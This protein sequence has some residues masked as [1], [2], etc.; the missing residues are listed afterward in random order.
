MSDE[1]VRYTMRTAAV[2]DGIYMRANCLV[3]ADC[4]SSTPT[5]VRTAE[6]ASRPVEG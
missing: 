5:A 1:T 3:H 4:V 2:Q 6:C